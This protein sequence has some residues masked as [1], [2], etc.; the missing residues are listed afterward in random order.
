MYW[1]R[2]SKFPGPAS[3]A[4]FYFPEFYHIFLGDS[5]VTTKQLHE[6][7]GDV[8]RVV[9]DGLTF[10]SESAWIGTYLK[11]FQKQK[12]EEEEKGKSGGGAAISANAS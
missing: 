12:E 11:N 6:K 5:H 8:V 3:R 7:Y 10:T 9:P 1:H 4:A 2:L